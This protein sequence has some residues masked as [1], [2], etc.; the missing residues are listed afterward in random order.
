MLIHKYERVMKSFAARQFLFAKEKECH[1]GKD[2]VKQSKIKIKQ[3]E[4]ESWIQHI[5]LIV[6]N[7]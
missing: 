2:T 4:M 7:K 3:N 5:S 1:K 6:Y